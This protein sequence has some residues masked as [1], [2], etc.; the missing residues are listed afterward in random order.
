[1]KT[2]MEGKRNRKRSK[3]PKKKGKYDKNVKKQ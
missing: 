3:D 1:M 2:K